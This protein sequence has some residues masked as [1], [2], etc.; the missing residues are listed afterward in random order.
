MALERQ[1]SRCNIAASSIDV[2]LTPRDPVRPDGRFIIGGPPSP[3]PC[4]AFDW[5]ESVRILAPGYF[6]E[7]FPGPD[8][9]GSALTGPRFSELKSAPLRLDRWRYLAEALPYRHREQA[10]RDVTWGGTLSVERRSRRYAWP[11]CGGR[12]HHGTRLLS[13]SDRG[14]N[15]GQIATSQHVVARG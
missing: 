14:D 7:V 6:E 15:P 11:S 2:S 3:A 8:V 9:R 4:L 12:V 10:D 13:R 5:V 1:A